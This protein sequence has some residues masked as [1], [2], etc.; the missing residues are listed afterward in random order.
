MTIEAPMELSELNVFTEI[1]KFAHGR[2]LRPLQVLI[3]ALGTVMLNAMVKP[4][5]SL[6]FLPE[7]K[8]TP[9]S[10]FSS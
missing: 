9:K 5:G 6:L 10:G 4:E 3:L 1:E 2:G 8:F 7:S